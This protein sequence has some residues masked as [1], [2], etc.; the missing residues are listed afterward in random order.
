VFGVGLLVMHD[1]G[2]VPRAHRLSAMPTQMRNVLQASID[3]ARN[4]GRLG[5]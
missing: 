4:P 3:F 5:C 1:L 2:F